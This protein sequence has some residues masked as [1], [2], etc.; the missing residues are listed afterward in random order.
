VGDLPNSISLV[1]SKIT[2]LWTNHKEIIMASPQSTPT[3][4]PTADLPII[5]QDRRR[6]GFFTLDNAVID[7]YG[8]EL[9]AHGIAVYTVLARFANR[10]GEC[11]PSQATIAKR[12][13]MSRM[14]V[15]RE[16]EKLQQ[17]QL[18]TVEPQYGLQG[19]QRANLYTLLEMPA[20]EEPVTHRYPPCNTPLH[21]PVTDSDTPRHRQ[22]HKQDPKNKTQQKQDP[23]E[24]Q[25]APSPQDIPAGSDAQADVVVA[26]T[27]LGISQKVARHLANHYSAERIEEKLAYLAFL[28]AEHPEKVLKPCGWLRK[29]IE[30]N[31]TAPDGYRT[32]E[33]RACEALEDQRYE[34][35]VQRLATE[36][37]QQAEAERGRQQQE[38]AVHLADLHAAYGTTQQELDLWS[39]L[40][41]EFRLGMPETSFL[42]YVADTILL[43]LK[44]GEALIGLPNA[45]ARDWME[46]RFAAKIRRTLASCLGGQKLT[47]RFIDL[48][49]AT[50]LSSVFIS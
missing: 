26:L 10:E 27:N 34:E 33:E 41:P 43:S 32:D 38:A 23:E 2:F 9:K 50:P 30:E 16:V 15:S 18:I 36:Q 37:R 40:L 46:N 24:Q 19:E 48:S 3:A 49:L 12:T 39:Q 11:F 42:Y 35:E 25:H 5:V 28:Q 14:Q 44:D 47:V 20:G 1:G 21:P 4:Q 6:R 29:A 31:Y 22:L 7:R 45:R 13:G 8:P 17:L